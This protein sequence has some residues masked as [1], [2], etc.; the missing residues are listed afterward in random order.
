MMETI[1]SFVSSL[2]QSTPFWKSAAL[3]FALL[4]LKSLPIVWHVRR[5]KSDIPRETVN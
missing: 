5:Y 3:F 1:K 2:W 4:N